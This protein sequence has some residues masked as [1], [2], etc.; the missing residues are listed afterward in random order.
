[1]LFKKKER[2]KISVEDVVI[3]GKCLD[4]VKFSKMNLI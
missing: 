4:E 1:M 2:K 3:V